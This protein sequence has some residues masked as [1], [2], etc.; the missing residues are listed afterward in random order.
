MTTFKKRIAVFT[1]MLMAT[2]VAVQF[3]AACTDSPQVSDEYA[4]TADYNNGVTGAGA[5]PRTYYVKRG[6][7][8]ASVDEPRAEWYDFDGWTSSAEGG[9][10]VTFPLTPSQDMTIYAQWNVQMLT[11][12]FDFTEADADPV[13][14]EVEYGG[15]VTPPFEE[16]IPEYP[17]Y[18]FREWRL[19]NG[20]PA[21]FAS[22]IRSDVTYYAAW[23]SD[24]T[25]IYN[26]NFNANYP[27]AAALPSQ[28]VVAGEEFDVDGLPQ[29]SRPGYE[30]IGWADEAGEIVCETLDGVF[31]ASRDATFY[32]TFQIGRASCRERV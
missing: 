30:F 25:A 15:T 19:E 6:E 8:L 29:V 22:P 32:I 1:A 18:K 13:T 31:D 14:T 12:T 23:L 11:V 20:N 26:V 21:N 9:N 3:A 17:G 10:E 2:A 24:D 28:T 4:V 16:Q 7:A 27:D 5:L